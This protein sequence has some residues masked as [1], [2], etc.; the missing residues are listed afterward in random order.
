MLRQ[1][2]KSEGVINLFGDRQLEFSLFAEDTTGYWAM[3]TVH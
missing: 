1:S 2:I 3:R